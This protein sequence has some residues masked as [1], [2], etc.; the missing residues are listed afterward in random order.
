M[1]FKCENTRRAYFIRTHHF[2]FFECFFA[3]AKEKEIKI[4]KFLQSIRLLLL[5]YTCFDNLPIV[6]R[7]IVNV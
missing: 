3:R 1:H 6:T 7:K 2:D 5:G 4:H